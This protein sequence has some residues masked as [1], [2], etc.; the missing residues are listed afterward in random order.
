MLGCRLD[1]HVLRSF[2]GPYLSCLVGLAMLVVIFD[3][4]DRVDECFRLIHERPGG[5]TRA[6]ADIGAFYAEQAL[7]FISNYGGLS[8]LAAAAL[9][10]AALAR[11]SELTATR[12][13]GISLRRTFL[14]LLLFGLLCGAGQLWLAES[15]VRRL[16][17]RADAALDAIM[18]RTTLR[19]VH[20]ERSTRLTV[21]A[22]L[23]GGG[24]ERIWQGRCRAHVWARSVEAGGRVVKELHITVSPANVSTCYYVTADA[25]RWDRR[26]GDWI[27]QGGKFNDHRED[28]A[29]RACSRLRC[30]ISPAEL[31]TGDLG[32][33]GVAS[34]KLYELRDD[35]APRVELWRRWT[36]PLV[37]FTLLL[38][39]L[40]LAVLGGSRGGKLLP[41][42]MALML[43]A[44]YILSLELG[45]QMA[46]D[47]MLLD[48]LARFEGARWLIA[49]GGPA[50]MAVDL[51]MV[52]PCLVFLATGAVLYW[53]MDRR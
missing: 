6:F 28:R 40:P 51:A 38:L 26:D 19:D 44:V 32:L 1:R 14:P 33:S 15:A 27:L 35:P 11:N 31:E 52:L 29:W 37:N 7:S 17:P 21:W 49:A 5:L 12:A 20:K 24:D 43:G 53:R 39:G 34:N 36:L 30:S 50:R 3:L 25:A 41:L 47:A 4:F 13:S 8:A 46:R 22:A 23:P 48:L 2:L 10:V 42:G 18:K 45:A 9:A 16:A